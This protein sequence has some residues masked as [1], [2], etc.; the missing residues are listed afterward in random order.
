MGREQTYRQIPWIPGKIENLNL[1]DI[2]RQVME[3]IY[4]EQGRRGPGE[5]Y[6]SLNVKADERSSPL[7]FRGQG[8]RGAGA[9]AFSGVQNE[10]MFLAKGAYMNDNGSWIAEDSTAVIQ[11]MNRDSTTPIMYRNTEL[12]VGQVFQ[13]TQVGAVVVAPPPAGGGGTVIVIPGTPPVG[14]S[15][16][17]NAAEVE[18]DFG[19]T[20]T[21]VEVFEFDSVFDLDANARV[22]MTPS[23]RPATGRDEDEAEFDTF[24]C[25]AIPFFDTVW[26]IRAYIHSLRGVVVGPYR[27]T[28]SVAV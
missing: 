16:A 7:R 13:P 15:V 8:S 9:I 27:F 12:V 11:E 2:V 10:S 20:D 24:S 4:S 25:A 6:D 18:L 3:R 17:V 14:P 26:R 1:N 5:R 28:Y 23:G 19:L 22:L 21:T